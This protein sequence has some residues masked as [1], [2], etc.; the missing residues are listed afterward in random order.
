M[1]P[2]TRISP[3][4]VIASTVTD[5]AE[6]INNVM[7]FLEV[8]VVFYQTAGTVKGCEL[9]KPMTIFF[10]IRNQPMLAG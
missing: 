4:I 5:T 10:M 8:C 7:M 1:P 9:Y 2:H 6:M 3:S